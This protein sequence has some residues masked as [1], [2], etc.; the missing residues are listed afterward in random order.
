MPP[1]AFIVLLSNS[2]DNAIEVYLDD[3]S[4]GMTSVQRIKVS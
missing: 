3:K 1:V 2:V 4:V